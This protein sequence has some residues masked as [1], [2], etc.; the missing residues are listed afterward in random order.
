MRSLLL[1]DR[2][3]SC[4]L[5]VEVLV[6]RFLQPGGV[7]DFRWLHARGLRILGRTCLTVRPLLP[8]PDRRIELAL[9]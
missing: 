9:V 2:Y 8:I 4:H 7:I 6:A 5:T 1:V 3:A